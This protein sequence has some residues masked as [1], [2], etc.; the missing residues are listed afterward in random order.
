MFPKALLNTFLLALIVAANP[1]PSLVK[2]P[3]TRRL[4][5]DNATALEHFET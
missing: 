2:L 1:V 3:L 4:N 5:S